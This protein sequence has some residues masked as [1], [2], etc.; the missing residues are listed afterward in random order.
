MPEAR[1]AHPLRE[2]AIETALRAGAILRDVHR[3]GP[4]RIASKSSRI[5]LVTEADLASERLIVEAIRTRCPEH[6]I[7]AEESAAGVPLEETFW[8][9]DPLDG[10]TNFAHGFPCFAVSLALQE[11]GEIVLG[12]V[13][14][15]LREEC[16]WAERGGGAWLRYAGSDR[17]L[18]VSSTAEL[19]QSLLAT[20]FSYQRAATAD[21]NLLEFNYFLPKVQGIRRAGAATLDMAYLA[22]G[23][24]DGYWE[25]RLSPWDWAAGALL[26]EE[27]GGKVCDYDGR[28][29]HVGCPNII[30]SNGQPALHRALLEGV[31]IARRRLASSVQSV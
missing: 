8:L 1:A 10:T 12:V 13:Y 6:G 26:V 4:Q 15:P 25:A 18:K 7:F 22:A 5:D 3:R 16:Y 28:P 11:A 14:D 9:I 21:N 24:L 31:Q 30:A 23:I 17:A 29:W 19:G 27:A 2:F 20:G